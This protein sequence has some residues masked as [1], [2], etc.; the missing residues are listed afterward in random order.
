MPILQDNTG[1][2][3]GDDCPPWCDGLHGDD[4]VRAPGQSVHVRSAGMQPVV[5]ASES[6]GGV[7]EP[8][9]TEFD[10]LRYQGAG[11]RDEWVFVGDDSVGFTVSRESAARICRAL[12]AVLEEWA[13]Y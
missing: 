5:A 1:P 10:V 6:G 13:P 9:S 3:P 12:G 2:R 4:F 8:Y 7:M 11:D